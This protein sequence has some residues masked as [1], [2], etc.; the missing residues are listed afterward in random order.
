M[1]SAQRLALFFRTRLHGVL[2]LELSGHFAGIECDPALLYQA[3]LDG[4]A[5]R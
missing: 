4:L 3:E 1:A 5:V 2:S